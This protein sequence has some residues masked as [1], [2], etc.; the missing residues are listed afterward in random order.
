MEDI[1]NKYLRQAVLSSTEEVAEYAR[2]NHAYKARTGQL[3]RSVKAGNSSDGLTGWLELDRSI[4]PYGP[5]VHEGTRPHT[6]VPRYMLALRWVADGKFVFAKRVRHPGY[7]GDPFLFNALDA[8][9]EKIFEIFSRR[10]DAALQEIAKEL[11]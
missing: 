1:L 6:I 4:A 9:E 8:N 7:E 5:Y 2:T 11:A 10:V 3:E